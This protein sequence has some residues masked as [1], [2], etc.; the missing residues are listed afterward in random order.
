MKT[1]IY[2]ESLKTAV[3]VIWLTLLSAAAIAQSVEIK[4]SYG[5]SAIQEAKNSLEILA[6]SIE[7][8]I[9]YFAP[10]EET[11]F[12]YQNLELLASITEK[13]LVYLAPSI[14]SSFE[15]IMNRRMND[16]L[17]SGKAYRPVQVELA[18]CTMQERWLIRAGY[19]KNTRTPAW[20]HIK[21]A[22]RS[23]KATKQYASAF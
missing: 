10:D 6:N 18:N 1:R 17:A 11:E 5:A 3:M 12:A 20:N 15:S 9:Q 7:K 16:E 22:F 23:K 4:G 19:Y 21:N 8:Q 14:E 13:T 2:P